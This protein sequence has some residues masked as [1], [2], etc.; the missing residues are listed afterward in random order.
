[1][2]RPRRGG[3]GARATIERES[4][5]GLIDRYLRRADWEVRENANMT[6]SLQ[7][8]NF[9]VITH[10]TRAYWLDRIYSPEIKQAH[11]DGDFHLHDLQVLGTY[12]EGW[13][14]IDLLMTGFQGAPGK[15]ESRPARHF[16][17]ALSQIVN[18]FYTLQGESA[19]AQAFSNFDTLLAPF[20]R[21][22]GL[23]YQQVKQ[24]VQEFVFNLNIPTRVGFQAPFTNLSFDLVPPA[25]L[26]E[27]GAII[28]GQMRDEPYR[29]FQ[30]EMDLL[31]KAFFE[32][33]TEGDSR[34][35]AFTFP[36]P[37]Y[38]IT[39][40]FDWDDA[41]LDGLWQMTA[42]YGIPYFANFV[43]SALSPEDVRSMCC[44]LRLDTRKLEHRG[45]G[46]FGANPLTGS[47]GVVTLNMPRLGH[48]AK[49]EAELFERLGALM[50]LAKDSLEIKRQA[51]EAFI[52]N[53]LYPYSQFY[54]RA[55]RQRFGKYWKNHFLTIGLVG[56]HEACL[57]HLGVGIDDARGRAFALAVLDF[58]RERLVAYQME[59]G[60]NY[61][62]EATP[63]E[64][65]GYRLAKRD[66]ERF[67]DMRAS[68]RDGEPFYTN[69]T[70]LPVD[71][72]EDPFAVLDH[73]D[74][75]QVKYTG[76]TVVHFFL[77]ERVGDIRAMRSFIRTVCEKY[78]L[79]Y[80]TLTPSF[81]V[82]P[83]H[84]YIAGAHEI[85][86]IGS[87]PCEVYSRVVGY[88]RPTRQWNEGKRAE[89]RF[90]KSFVLP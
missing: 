87:E 35:R 73:Q 52:E 43:N 69:S 29:A 14:L 11:L 67:P 22:D 6:F 57:E 70:Q 1:M 65:A 31:N 44:R 33:M 45:G 40:G 34:G 51:L 7:G 17:S 85:C 20:I 36:I 64:S 15:I 61:N 42:K 89:F 5:V 90:R 23:T 72:T 56:M 18:F 2:K 39:K 9:Y 84:G 19:G 10:A 21:H 32:V 88:L 28:G 54:L 78:R 48:L 82:C 13:D 63:A 77:G 37:T 55:I 25:F 3:S 27:Q 60:N 41:R 75:L 66:R 53:G 74:E 86:P 71:F 83:V 46:Y 76:G 58:M 38:S 8:L 62:L 16:S 26:A 30:K 80:F 81:S 47:I 59:T 68:R 49:T 50:D 24:S 12:C 4:Q 79:P